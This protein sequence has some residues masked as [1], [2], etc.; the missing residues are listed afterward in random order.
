M[1]THPLYDVA[2]T[3]SIFLHRTILSFLN[4]WRQTLT[5]GYEPCPSEV[6]LRRHSFHPLPSGPKITSVE[7][8]SVIMAD[9]LAAFATISALVIRAFTLSK[10]V[11]IRANEI[12]N[13]PQHIRAI[14][15]DLEDFYSLLGTLTMYLDEESDLS[16]GLVHSAGRTNLEKVLDNCITVFDRTN[17]LVGSYKAIG[18]TSISTWRKM[19]YSF[20][21]TET[22]ALRSELAA[23]KLSLN[24]AI[25]LVNLYIKLATPQGL[26]VTNND[27]SQYK[28][29]ECLLAEIGDGNHTPFS[30]HRRKVT[31]NPTKSR[32]NQSD[33]TVIG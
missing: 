2:F 23:H 8:S 1:T 9:P 14:T 19:K 10:D 15:S 4:S 13:A 20:K 16:V 25:S 22:E 6:G 18:G 11:Y 21:L 26:N 32:R 31:R 28:H 33:Y 17:I 3:A 30:L 27:Q 24:I 29:Q 5:Q 7:S 12:T